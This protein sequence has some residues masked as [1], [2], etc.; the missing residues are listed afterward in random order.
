MSAYLESTSARDPKQFY[1]VAQMTV[2]VLLNCK[3]YQ[4]FLVRWGQSAPLVCVIMCL[5]RLLGLLKL[6]VHWLQVYGFSP[7]CVRRWIFRLPFCVKRFPHCAHAYGFSPVWMR[8]WMLSVVLL[9]ND[10]PHREQGT[11]DSPVWLAR[12]TMRSS[13]LWKRSPQKLQSRDLLAVW[14]K[15]FC[16]C[17]NWLMWLGCPTWPSVTT[18]G[19][20]NPG[21][22]AVGAI[23][24][25]LFLS[26]WLFL[27]SP[28]LLSC[29]T[30][31]GALSLAPVV[32]FR[33]L[34]WPTLWSDRELKAWSS[35]AEK[36]V[37]LSS[38]RGPSPRPW[39]HTILSSS[40][41][42]VEQEEPA[43]SKFWAPVATPPCRLW[44]LKSPWSEKTENSIFKGHYETEALRPVL[45]STHQ[46]GTACV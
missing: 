9:T 7:E 31:I 6:A 16:C 18:S 28:A 1:T 15:T 27:T 35:D 10:L 45:L 36:R 46:W 26:S 2:K 13:R 33:R 30:L 44:F 39:T 20:F 3:V 21:F 37:S 34:S 11:G 4:V 5:R 43:G 17:G 12:C 41:S 24:V 38:C 19:D 22:N 14:G 8:M 32:K 40:L 25:E 42:P 29:V 23:C